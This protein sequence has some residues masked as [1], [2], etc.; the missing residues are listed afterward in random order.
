MIRVGVVGASGFVGTELMRI[1]ALHP[2]VQIAYATSRSH[3]GTRF[4]RIAPDLLGVCDIELTAAPSDDADVVFLAVPH[5]AARSVLEQY[6]HLRSSIVVDLSSDHRADPSFVYGS[7]ELHRERLRTA[8][9][10]AN[11]GCFATALLLSLLPLARNEN[12]P[13]IV[14][15]S[16]ITGSTGAGAEPSPTLH[17]SWRFANAQPYSILRHRHAAEVTAAL[18]T[19]A[20]LRFV[21][22]RGAFTRGIATTCIVET[23]LAEHALEQLFRD[24]YAPHPLVTISDDVPDLKWVV[25]TARAILHTTVAD[26]VA[27][28]V[29]VLDNMLKGAA[30]QAVQNMNLALGFDECAGLPLRGIGW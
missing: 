23:S 2:H 1:L 19:G 5:G 9:R 10:I 14:H 3:A 8:R 15:A 13:P 21:P 27:A 30:A 29:C 7:P 16:G 25:G 24:Y 20:Q 28:I 17:F 18:G 11:P 4:G 6:P 12:L 22:Y 26:G